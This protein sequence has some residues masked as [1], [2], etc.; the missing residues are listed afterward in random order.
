MLTGDKMETAENIGRSCNLVQDHFAVMKLQF[1]KEEGLEVLKE[2]LKEINEIKH[3]Y[4]EIK[5]PKA[6]IVEGENLGEITQN[7]QTELLF[8]EIVKTCEAVICCRVTP[9]QKADVVALVKKHLNKITLSIG[10]GANDVNMI[11]EAHIGIG[12]YGEEGMRA[13]QASDFAFVKFN[14]LWKLILVHGKWSY[15]RISEMILYFFYKNMVF[16]ICQ[17]YFS[18]LCGWSGQTIYDDYYITFYNLVFTALP[19]IVRAV[20][21][22]DVYYRFPIKI[23]KDDLDE[24][25]LQPYEENLFLKKYYPKLYY[26]GQKNT[27]FTYKNFF[28]W[29]FQGIIHGL[30]IFLFNM[31]IY[32]YFIGDSE[33]KTT[34]IW[35]MSITLYTSIILV[36]SFKE[37]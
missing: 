34:D 1:K 3:Q 9:K 35:I 16:T 15:I 17:F 6:F 7:F 4:E 29:I 18:F 28:M 27:L 33:G 26:I 5:K 11:Q 25:D 22:Q 21:E 23:N 36:N 13:V 24:N 31:Y 19:V 20:I 30:F 10:D 2:K 12:L 14:C 37:R 8:I 32:S